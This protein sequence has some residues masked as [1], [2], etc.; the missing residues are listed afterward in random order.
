MCNTSTKV[1]I[2]KVSSYLELVDLS[3]QKEVA[4]RTSRYYIAFDKMV[5]QERDLSFQKLVTSRL[6]KRTNDLI[7]KINTI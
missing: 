5:E 6:R 7:K 2:N 4:I 3:E 1:Q